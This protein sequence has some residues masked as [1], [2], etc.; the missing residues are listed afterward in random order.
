[1]ESKGTPKPGTQ[2]A[3]DCEQLGALL[4]A[5]SIGATD[6]DEAAFVE[7]TL[8]ACPEAAAELAAYREL[9]RLLGAELPLTE[10]PARLRESLLMAARGTAQIGAE[11]PA[12]IRA[13]LQLSAKRP[14]GLRIT[15]ALVATV[16]LVLAGALWALRELSR[17]RADHD[18]LA[19]RVEKQETL[20]ET[21]QAQD[22]RLLRLPAAS[23]SQGG[24][25]NAL[26]VWAPSL[27]QGMLM[28]E[29]FPALEVGKTFQ[30][31]VTRGEDI[32]SLGTFRSNARGEGYLVLPADLLDT[33]FDSLGVTIEPATGSERPTSKPVVRLEIAE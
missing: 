15:L 13:P 10:P 16:A 18:W 25:T 28:A 21:F 2:P 12:G 6:R 23:G 19:E 27:Q 33:P 24:D 4:P 3:A 30:A 11:R 14:G 29:K 20:I 17:L 5:Y 31:W 7:A 32:T 26:V 1:V 9:A 22:A 8:D